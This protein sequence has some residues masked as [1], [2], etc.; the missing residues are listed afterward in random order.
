MVG[1][2]DE[3][4]YSYSVKSIKWFFLYSGIN[5]SFDVSEDNQF[6]WYEDIKKKMRLF[7]LKMMMSYI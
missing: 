1:W 5:N 3:L 4:W 7:K 6:R 2:F